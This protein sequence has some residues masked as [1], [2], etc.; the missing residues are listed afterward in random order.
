MRIWVCYDK[1]LTYEELMSMSVGTEV[2]CE[3]SDDF[4]I[5]T[6]N[7]FKTIIEDGNMIG[8]HGNVI[9]IDDLENTIIGNERYVKV[10][11]V[12]TLSKY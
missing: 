7:E 9:S 3:Y 4:N 1:P 12:N 10:Y 6:R 2:W 8:S 11:K 5:P